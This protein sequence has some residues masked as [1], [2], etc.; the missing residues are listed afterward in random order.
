MRILVLLFAVLLVSCAS[1]KT[2]P[3]S[4]YGGVYAPGTVTLEGQDFVSRAG[5]LDDADQDIARKAAF[6]RFMLEAKEAGYRSFSISEE[7]FSQVLGTSFTVRGNVYREARAGNGI[8]RLDAIKRLLRDL[9]LAQPKPKPKP[10]A[11]PS[12]RIAQQTPATPVPAPAPEP[13]T[14][15]P[16]VIMA[17]EDITGSIRR[18]NVSPQAS[19]PVREGMGD[20]SPLSGDSDFIR[21]GAVSNLPMGVV[22]RRN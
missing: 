14:E 8:Y 22:L 12:K 4:F 10:V 20:L 6:A 9:P 2:A 21:P 15:D 19:A 16:L 5:V 3:K 13:A 11:R 17:P 18:A 1:P 7:K